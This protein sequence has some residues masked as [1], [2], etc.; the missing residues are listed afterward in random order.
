MKD[1]RLNLVDMME[2]ACRVRDRM[3][4]LTLSEFEFNED[5]QLAITFL[6]QIIGEAARSVSQTT[7]DGFPRIPWKQITGMRHRIVQ[8][9][10]HINFKRVWE[11]ALDDIPQL[12]AELTA[13]VVPII[14]E[15]KARKGQTKL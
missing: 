10:L 8:D 3:A 4:R 14:A 15:A 9:Y 2:S 13:T 11:V 5:V 1:D 12:I 6:L 7:R